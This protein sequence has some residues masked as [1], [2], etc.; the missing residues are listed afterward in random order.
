MRRGATAERESIEGD[1]PADG[2]EDGGGAGG[3]R[4]RGAGSGKV[5]ARLRAVR[6]RCPVAHPV[7]RAPQALV[8][9]LTVGGV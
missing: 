1:E 6:D 2:E 7:L 5:G 9:A 3:Q 8:A 4:Q